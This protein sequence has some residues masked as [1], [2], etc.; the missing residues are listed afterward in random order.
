MLNEKLIRLVSDAGEYL[1]LEETVIEKDYYVT[2][3]IHAL[4]SVENEYFQLVFC[5][6]TCLSKAYKIVGRMSEDV[7][8]KIQIKKTGINFSKNRLLKELKNFRLYIKSKLVFPDLIISEPIV[9]NEGQYLKIEIDY[10]SAFPVN[11]GLRPHILLEFT[12]SEIRLV[13][14]KMLIKTL[15][16]DSIENT[17]LFIP[18][19]T[20]CVSIEETAIEKWVGLTRR[21]IAIER[22]YHPDDSTLIRHVYDLNSIKSAKRINAKFFTLAKEIVIS[23]ARQFKNLHPEYSVDPGGEIQQSLSLLKSNSLWKERYYEFIETMV[24]NN[25]DVLDYNQAI[26][27]LEHISTEVIYAL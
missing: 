18:S 14:E 6:G 16:E 24:Y 21:V 13:V 9:R 5:G 23:D 11:T 10:S 2:Q 1:G 22:G 8:F 3:V 20:Q 15:I 27:N 7:D 12:F 26:E 19:L 17:E 4:S 25:N